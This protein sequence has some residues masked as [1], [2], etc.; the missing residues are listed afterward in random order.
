MLDLH[1]PDALD[2]P[3]PMSLECL[4]QAH[5]LICE[6]GLGLLY[7]SGWWLRFLMVTIFVGLFLIF[8][9]YHGGDIFLLKFLLKALYLFEWHQ[10][11]FRV[12]TQHIGCKVV[13]PTNKNEVKIHVLLILL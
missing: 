11:D 9:V 7:D 5:P 1:G 3:R 10:E 6:N 12:F 13:F 4:S 8:V 2:A